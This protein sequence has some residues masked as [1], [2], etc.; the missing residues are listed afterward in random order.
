[1]SQNIF[2]EI[3]HTDHNFHFIPTFNL[4]CTYPI[5]LSKTFLP[6]Q[7]SVYTSSIYV[8]FLTLG[9]IWNWVTIVGFEVL[10]V[11]VMKSTVSWDIMLCSPS[12]QV[13]F[14]SKHWLTFN[15]LHSIISQKI[16]IFQVII[17]CFSLVARHFNTCISSLFM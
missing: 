17:V 3:V 11:L 4:K 13:I 14:S 1:M 7:F 16:V 5:V 8:V 12:M 10:T 15:M 2:V 6:Q 9:N